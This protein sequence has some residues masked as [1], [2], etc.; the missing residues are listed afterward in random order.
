MTFPKSVAWL[1]IV[2]AVFGALNTVDVLALV[3]PKVGVVI[4]LVSTI[5]A[6]LSRALMDSDGDGKPDGF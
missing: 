6:S 2:A 5:L 3:G 1:S 4:T